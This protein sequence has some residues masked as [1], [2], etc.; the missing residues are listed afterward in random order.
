MSRQLSVRERLRLRL[1]V[2][3]AAAT[4]ESEAL[5]AD[6]FSEHIAAQLRGLD[7]KQESAPT[8]EPPDSALLETPTLETPTLEPPTLEPPTLE[9]PT[10]H[11]ARPPRRYANPFRNAAGEPLTPSPRMLK[12]EVDPSSLDVTATFANALRRH[13]CVDVEGTER[14]LVFSLFAESYDVFA[15]ALWMPFELH[16]KA[17]F[18]LPDNE[19]LDAAISRRRIFVDV[20]TSIYLTQGTRRN[21]MAMNVAVARRRTQTPDIG[22]VARGEVE[23]DAGTEQT[24]TEFVK[25]DALR[26]VYPSRSADAWASHRSII[27]AARAQAGDTLRTFFDGVIA[28]LVANTVP[29][30]T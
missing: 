4:L 7:L 21:A 25:I 10:S 20:F 12:H 29:P 13:L 24:E 14:V 15:P 9:P 23:L 19:V 27:E 5:R 3:Q 26:V 16:R 11:T 22:A 18:I 1:E 2:K 6:A 17:A 8:L 28:R 30:P